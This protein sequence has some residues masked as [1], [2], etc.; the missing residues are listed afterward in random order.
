V[1]AA[2]EARIRPVASSRLRTTAYWTT[3]LLVVAEFSIGGVMD[4]LQ[5]PPFHAALL[6]LGYPA[7]FSVIMGVWKVL[8][9]MAVLAPRLPRLKEWAYAGMIINLTTAVAS[10]LA[11]G[12]SA[13][14]VAT[15]LVFTGLVAASWATRPPSRWLP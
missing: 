3:T 6:H 11:M 7:Y 2:L 5:L 4:I 14:D 12:G 13:G 10:S 15:P 1:S 9:A 8:G